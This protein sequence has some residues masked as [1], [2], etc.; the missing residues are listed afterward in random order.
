MIQAKVVAQVITGIAVQMTRMPCVQTTLLGLV[1][2]T[3]KGQEGGEINIK[4]ID[5][6]VH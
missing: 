4:G 5:A 6:S 3:W 2:E 1:N